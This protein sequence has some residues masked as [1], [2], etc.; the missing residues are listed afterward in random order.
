MPE[1]GLEPI[2]VIHPRD[3]KSRASANS[4]TP[5]FTNKSQK[6][7]GKKY[8]KAFIANF[9]RMLPVSFAL[10]NTRYFLPISIKKTT[11]KFRRSSMF[12]F[13]LFT[14][15][16]IFLEAP[17]GIEPTNKSFADSCL[18]TWLRCRKWKRT[19]RNLCTFVKSYLTL[20]PLST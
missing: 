14:L 3:F 1:I 16:L 4:A 12:Y 18:T 20:K 6:L 9:Y 8:L 17:D 5:A 11:K 10:C 2:R 13:C 19:I 15:N 7:K